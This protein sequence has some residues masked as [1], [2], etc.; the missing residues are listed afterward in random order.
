MCVYIINYYF[1]VV[2]DLLE[3]IEFE[4]EYVLIK[5]NNLMKYE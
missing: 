2:L 3:F 5:D 4:K 1:G